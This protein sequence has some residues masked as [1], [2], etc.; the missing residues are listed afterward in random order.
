MAIRCFMLRP[1]GTARL[2]LRRYADGTCPGRYD[3]HNATVLTDVTTDEART[4]ADG[5]ALAG[6]D[7][8]EWPH[9]DERWPTRCDHC[10]YTFG[11]DDA[12]QPHMNIRWTRGDD[13]GLYDGPLHETP[14]GAMWDAWWVGD[15]RR[16][17]DGVALCVMLPDDTVW[18]IDGPATGGG[19]WTRTGDPPVVTV[20]PSIQSVG[21]HGFLTDGVLTDPL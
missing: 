17:S 16:G 3:Y 19:R 10:P 7:V 14:A 5:S 1:T 18:D 21:Y 2:R 12:W 13:G 4:T 15:D 6:W 20:T 8:S 11:A 9:E